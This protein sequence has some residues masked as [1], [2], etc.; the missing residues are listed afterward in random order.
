GEEVFRR[1]FDKVV[2]GLLSLKVPSVGA[3]LVKIE[4]KSAAI[5]LSLA[6]VEVYGSKRTPKKLSNIA[7]TKETRQSSTDYNGFSRLAVD[8]NKNGDYGHHSVTHT[9]GDSPSWWEIDLAQTEELEKLIIYNRT[10]A[11]I[12]RLSNFDIIIYDSNNHEVFKQHIDSLESNNLS[13]DLKGL[14]GKKV[15]ISL[16]NAGIPLSLA[17]VEVYTYK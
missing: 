4:L 17:E 2:D 15:R 13:I 1:H 7:L 9:K 16:R 14:K 11:E 5:P 3:K 10:D 12:Q 6:E 8:G